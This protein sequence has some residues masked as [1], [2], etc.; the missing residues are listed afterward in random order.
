MAMMVLATRWLACTLFDLGQ[1]PLALLAAE[2]LVGVATYGLF[3]RRAI[4]WFL[5]EGL[6]DLG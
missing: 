5:R 2:V 1:R 4:G 6:R 3:S